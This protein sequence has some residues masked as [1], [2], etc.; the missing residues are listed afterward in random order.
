MMLPEII[1]NPQHGS[2][3][4]LEEKYV[5]VT[6]LQFVPD[7]VGECCKGNWAHDLRL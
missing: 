4:P 1:V 7:T 3:Q 2:F 5:F 6:E